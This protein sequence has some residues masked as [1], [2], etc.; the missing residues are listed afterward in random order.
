MRSALLKPQMLKSLVLSALI[1]PVLASTA[2]AD[3]IDGDW[4]FGTLTLHVSGPAIR[5]PGGHDITGDYARHAFRYTVP[6][7]EPQSG[8]EIFMQLLNEEEMTL[9]RPSTADKPAAEER[10]TRCHPIS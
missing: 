7:D 3:R 8:A 1:G 2:F 5:T 4:C 6:A 9:F 10:W